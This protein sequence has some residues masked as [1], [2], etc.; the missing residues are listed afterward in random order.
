[1][2]E[3]K[4]FVRNRYFLVNDKVKTM[5]SNINENQSNS[6]MLIHTHFRYIFKPRFLYG[7]DVSGAA[8]LLNIVM[9]FIRYR[10]KTAKILSKCVNSISKLCCANAFS[11][12]LVYTLKFMNLNYLL[13]NVIEF[14]Q[15]K[16]VTSFSNTDI[17]IRVQGNCSWSNVVGTETV[18]LRI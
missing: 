15:M 8:H 4:S 17:K 12:Y 1:M 16:R 11:I 13:H 9:K 3:K 14:V 6:L 2:S 7:I 18:V 5:M 10:N